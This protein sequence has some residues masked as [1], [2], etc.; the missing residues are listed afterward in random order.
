M[1]DKKVFLDE[2]TAHKSMLESW[3]KEITQEI[4]EKNSALRQVRGVRSAKLESIALSLLPDLDQ[5]YLPKIEMYFGKSFLLWTDVATLRMKERGRI[6]SMIENIIGS[7]KGESIESRMIEIDLKVTHLLRDKENYTQGVKAIEDQYGFVRL[8]QDG[9]DTDSYTKSWFHFQFYKDWYRADK[10]TEALGHKTWSGVVS[11]YEQNKRSILETEKDIKDHQSAKDYFCS[12]SNIDLKILEDLRIK[13][14]AG[15]DSLDTNSE[16]LVDVARMNA[17]IQELERSVNQD[18]Q[19]RRER[20]SLQITKLH[21]GISKVQKSRTRDVPEEIVSRLKDQ[22][23][24]RNLSNI[25]PIKRRTTY[26]LNDTRPVWMDDRYY[27]PDDCFDRAFDQ[28]AQATVI[29]E[30]RAR[31]YQPTITEHV[32]YSSFNQDNGQYY[33]DDPANESRYGSVS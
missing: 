33:N 19:P 27:I 23:R 24:E 4:D 6:I 11:D 22:R 15:L 14:R 1:V 26:H 10:I 21:Q 8:Y 17:Q 29:V 20:V 16:L 31:D 3:L 7:T 25:V 13:I 18:L 32:S 30:D 28:F 12:L 9:W 2:L 5:R